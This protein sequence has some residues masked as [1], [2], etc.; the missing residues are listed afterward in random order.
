M[1]AVARAGRQVLL[2][3]GAG[4]G[5]V[6]LLVAV[7]APL[8][9]VRLLVFESGSMSPTIETG[10]IAVTKTVAAEDLAVGDIVSVRPSSENRVTHRIVGIDEAGAQTLLVLQG[11]ANQTPDPEPYPVSDADRVLL[12][13]N[14]LGF[15]VDALS[16]PY[17]VFLAGAFVAWLLLLAFR[18]DGAQTPRGRRRMPV[19]AAAVVVLASV[20]VGALLPSRVGPTTASFVD[21]AG[22]SASYGA[23]VL[24][25]P[26]ISSCTVTGGP[27]SQKTA[28][29]VWSEVGAWDYVAV[30]AET[31][32]AMTVTDNGATRHTQFSAGLLSTILNATYHV[33]I[34]SKHTGSPWTSVPATQPVTIALLG[35]GMSCGTAS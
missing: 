35:L 13:V 27:L 25:K 16:S 9:G 4:L 17:A 31:G 11:D 34:R 19:A 28:T 5:L 7:A 24:P 32:T 6:C 26:T 22:V 23:T 33:E 8:L 15:V 12:H 20:G 1:I 21:V 30:L 3:L 14:H 29:I 10:G 2:T 18:R